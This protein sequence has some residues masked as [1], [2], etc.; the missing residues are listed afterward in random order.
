ML[1]DILP[2]SMLRN[3]ISL[4]LA[5]INA[6]RNREHWL[7]AAIRKTPPAVHALCLDAFW[8]VICQDVSK[9]RIQ[10]HWEWLACLNNHCFKGY[11][12]AKIVPSKLTKTI[13]T[14]DFNLKFRIVNHL[15]NIT[16]Y[17][18]MILSVINSRE[19]GFARMLQ[20]DAVI[21]FQRYQMSDL[22]F[23]CWAASIDLIHALGQ[24]D[25]ISPTL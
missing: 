21:W 20:S 6:L 13:F 14:E 19:S 11:P 17:R 24:V 15:S 3:L 4:Q 2:A 5:T 16:W 22:N 1:F 9:I 18:Q 25:R 23:D 7:A 10:L 12:F 8:L